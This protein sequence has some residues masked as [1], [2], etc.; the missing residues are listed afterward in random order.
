[1]VRNIHTNKNFIFFFEILDMLPMW[2]SLF[3]A[4]YPFYFGLFLLVCIFCDISR[5]FL[6][7][8]FPSRSLLIIVMLFFYGF[9]A[10]SSQT[11]IRDFLETTVKETVTEEYNLKRETLRILM[12]CMKRLLNMSWC[13]CIACHVCTMQKNFLHWPTFSVCA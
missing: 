7:S 3:I 1:M 10:F 12:N 4:F 13:A 11:A 2:L 5:R 8:S 6:I 9:H